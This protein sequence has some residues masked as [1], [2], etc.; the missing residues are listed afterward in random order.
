RPANLVGDKFA[1]A[2]VVPG[3]QDRIRP[4]PWC[5]MPVQSSGLAGRLE[6]LD[7]AAQLDEAVGEV[8]ESHHWRIVLPRGSSP[9]RGLRALQ[10]RSATG[11]K[12]GRDS[13]R[14]PL[15]DHSELVKRPLRSAFRS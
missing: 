9:C 4:L 2:G 3:A 8:S 15:I 11:Q 10:A 12:R 14:S 5:A 13:R 1:P 6:L 7:L